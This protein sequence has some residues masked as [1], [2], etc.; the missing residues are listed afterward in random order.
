MTTIILRFQ[1]KEVA[2]A[3]VL[4]CVLS[5]GKI[6]NARKRGVLVGESIVFLR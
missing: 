5:P 2:H 1:V 3:G 4:A 6:D